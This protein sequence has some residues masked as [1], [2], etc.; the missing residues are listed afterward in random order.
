MGVV[1]TGKI[2]IEFC[3]LLKVGQEGK[4]EGGKG[5][6]VALKATSQ[7]GSQ[8]RQQSALR[9]VPTLAFPAPAPQGFGCR[10]L[11][12]DIYESDEL[13]TQGVQYVPLEQLLA[14]VGSWWG[15]VEGSGCAVQLLT[16]SSSRRCAGS[17]RIGRQQA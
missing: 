1:G 13:K 6:C 3:T 2:G 4:R 11:A 10:I 5:E 16:P 9:P 8:A 14:E 17:W 15:G 7:A 12:H